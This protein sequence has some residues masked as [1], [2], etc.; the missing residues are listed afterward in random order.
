MTS[1]KHG[2][3][4]QIHTQIQWN[5]LLSVVEEQAQTL[6]RTA[7]STSARE[8]GDISAGVY[9]TKGRML[10]QAVTGTP[11]HVNA[12]AASVGFFLQKY[13]ISK[14][15]EGEA[16]ITNDPWKGTGHLN[17]FTVVTPTFKNGQAVGL[18]AC[19]SHVVDVGGRG[20]GPDGRQVYEEGINIPI[21]PLVSQGRM[22]EK[23]L[24]IVRANVRNPIEVVGDL[25]SLV[26]CNEVGSNRLVDMMR[27][28]ELESID[29]LGQHIIDSSRKSMAEQISE[30]PNGTYH[31]EMRID[32]YEKEIDL[33]AALTVT[34]D[35]VSVDFTGTS[36]VSSYGINVPL[37]YTQAYASFGVRCVVGGDIPNNAGSLAAVKI[38]APEGSILNAPPPSA[39]TA[40]HVIGQM[41]PDVIMGCLNQI[42][43]DRVSAE[44]TSCLWN[45]VL[46]GG[47]GLTEEDYGDGQPFAMNTFHSGGTGARPSKDGLSATAFPSG[48]RNTPVEVNETIAPLIFWKKEYRTD[49]GGAGT[50]RGGLGQVMEI[51][52]SEG[53]PFAINSMF[54]RVIYPPRGRNGG[55]NGETGKLELASGKVMKGKG[56]QTIPTG[57]RLIVSMPGGGGLGDPAKRDPEALAIDVRDG[58]VSAEKASEDYGRKS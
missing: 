24:D 11:G 6:V 51:S 49:S 40:R 10:A 15:Q 48:V 21:L 7:F 3:L 23:I 45:P 4:D 56:R 33:V 35:T 26:A 2:A 54:D 12:M 13:P 20:F 5:R 16:Y 27:E 9:D 46:L 34:D 55:K 53:R 18:F 22:D 52:H 1:S 41:L 30:L 19:T 57:D 42:I 39:V 43:P 31:N 50:Y 36:G 25:Y 14:M 32:G 8:A 37:T 58:F 38:S 28:F 47:H 17:D 44:G 29:P